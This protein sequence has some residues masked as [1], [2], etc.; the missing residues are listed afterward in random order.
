MWTQELEN[1][2]GIHRDEALKWLSTAQYTEKDNI[3]D[4]PI[5]KFVTDVIR[6]CN[7]A[8]KTSP[9]T[10]L[11][12]IYLAM[13]ARLRILVSA[14]TVTTTLDAY[15]AKI[16]AKQKVM[17][18]ILMEETKATPV[19]QAVLYASD[20]YDDLDNDDVNLDNRQYRQDHRL[21]EKREWRQNWERNNKDQRS[22]RSNW[23][24]DQE[25][26]PTRQ[27]R[28]D[29]DDHRDDR[30][31]WQDDRQPR[32]WSMQVAVKQTYSARIPYETILRIT[33]PVMVSVGTFFLGSMAG[34][35]LPPPKSRVSYNAR[36]VLLWSRGEFSVTR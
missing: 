12:K 19:T 35:R 24:I 21:P 36:Q 25:I 13:H 26:R 33:G 5:R 11:A 6:N 8:K 31:H 9:E 28:R 3:Q 10:Q 22:D 34:F 30:H 29:R 23:Y 1:R 7:A 15:L 18:D 32:V 17:R 4:K 2:F 14:P 16:E 20:R 27:D